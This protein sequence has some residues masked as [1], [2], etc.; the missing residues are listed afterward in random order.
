MLCQ[1]NGHNVP[2]QHI[3]YITCSGWHAQPVWSR[4]CQIRLHH[5]FTS[6]PKVLGAAWQ[7]WRL[8]TSCLCGDLIF[9]QSVY[10]TVLHWPQHRPGS[11]KQAQMWPYGSTY[12]IVQ[13]APA[14]AEIGIIYFGLWCAKNGVLDQF[15]HSLFIEIPSEDILLA[16]TEIKTQDRQE[17]DRKLQSKPSR[18]SPWDTVL[19]SAGY[20]CRPPGPLLPLQTTVP[21]TVAAA[22]GGGRRWSARQEQSACNSS[23][24]NCTHEAS[25]QACCQSARAIR[26]PDRA[27]NPITR[28]RWHAARWN[29]HEIRSRGARIQADDC[30]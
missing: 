18:L 7:V 15:H 3:I 22:A 19:D 20:R 1:V 11:P 14:F 29:L 16:R 9:G 17:L 30:I 24:E 8:W 13:E 10:V 12:S 27:D 23:R 28:A 21:W 26:S 2:N 6:S 25:G 4:L 5:V